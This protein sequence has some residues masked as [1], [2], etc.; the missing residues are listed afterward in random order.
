M[1]VS[2][3]RPSLNPRSGGSGG[4]GAL[5]HDNFQIG[6]VTNDME[7]ACAVFAE[8]FGIRDYQSAGGG[9][10]GGGHMNAKLVWVGEVMYELIEAT[11]P[12]SEFYTKVLDPDQFSIRF[13]HS[14]FFVYDD[15]SWR[16]LQEDVA[17]RG[18]KVW[19]NRAIDG[20]IRIFYAE[21]PELGH[22]LEY[23]FPEP[24]GIKFFE[25]TPRV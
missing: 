21:V 13:H 22:C 20:F 15:P 11:G 19:Q 14:G 25:N 3:R 7:R 12:G 8:R 23:I 17:T 24:E 10:D 16:A 1:T 5:R 2:V 6:Y 18:W 4:G 9:L